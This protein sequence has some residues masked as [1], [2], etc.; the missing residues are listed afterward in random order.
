ML[1]AEKELILGAGSS[2]TV[3]QR[4]LPAPVAM[5]RKALPNA[6]SR[7]LE[8]GL[9]NARRCP[10]DA[11]QRRNRREL[12]K[13]FG[14]ENFPGTAASASARDSQTLRSFPFI[15][16]RDDWFVRLLINNPE[17]FS[18]PPQGLKYWDQLSDVDL[19][20]NSR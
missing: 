12:G 2:G 14:T 17:E 13:N 19:S 9:S 4:D 7:R 3:Q 16:V 10:I 20:T 18:K 8:S 1:T 5:R 11:W 15:E 6:G